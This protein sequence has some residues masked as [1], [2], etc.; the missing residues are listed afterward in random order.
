[1]VL[2]GVMRGRTA[3]M[4]VLREDFRAYDFMIMLR[5]WMFSGPSEG[6]RTVWMSCGEID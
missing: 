5:A 2:G 1:V 6:W 4:D 3:G